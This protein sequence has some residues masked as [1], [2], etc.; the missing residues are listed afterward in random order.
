[1]RRSYFMVI[2]GKIRA[3]ISQHTY[4]CIFVA[5]DLE[6]SLVTTYG[7]FRACSYYNFLSLNP[8][9]QATLR[10]ELRVSGTRFISRAKLNTLT[11]N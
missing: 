9:S 8:V 1:M 4:I 10:L 7:S 5:E 3:R 11:A 2:S 6:K